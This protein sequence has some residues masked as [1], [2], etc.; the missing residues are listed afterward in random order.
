MGAIM[1]FI[2]ILTSAAVSSQYTTPQRTMK[3]SQTTTTS[4]GPLAQSIIIL[5]IVGAA[6]L[7]ALL[8]TAVVVAIVWLKCMKATINKDSKP[9]IHLNKCDNTSTCYPTPDGKEDYNNCSP[10]TRRSENKDDDDTSSD[11]SDDSERF[12]NPKNQGSFE[13][14]DSSDNSDSSSTSSSSSSSQEGVTYV[15]LNLPP[16]SKAQHQME[17]YINLQLS[18]DYENLQSSKH[19]EKEVDYV[20]VAPVQETSNNAVQRWLSETTDYCSVIVK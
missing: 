13:S 12:H 3:T 8:I 16:T 19:T 2:F 20:N 10:L 15:T 1:L 6:V 14:S 18:E 17:D 7:G 9:A 11:S 4:P 5:C